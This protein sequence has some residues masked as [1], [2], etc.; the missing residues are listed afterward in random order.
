MEARSEVKQSGSVLSYTAW[1]VPGADDAKSYISYLG[2]INLSKK[3]K[4]AISII[5]TW[6]GN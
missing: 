3:D 2:S 4:K 6:E 1:Q 5:N